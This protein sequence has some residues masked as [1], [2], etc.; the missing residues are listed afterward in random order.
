MG[1]DFLPSR[2]WPLG[3]VS[4]PFGEEVPINSAAF[5]VDGWYIG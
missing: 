5:Q 4:G 3:R 1:T 2:S